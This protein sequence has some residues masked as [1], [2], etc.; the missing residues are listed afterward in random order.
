MFG[1][2]GL[3]ITCDGWDLQGLYSAVSPG[4]IPPR[5][6][7]VLRR[8]FRGELET[9][10]NGR[11]GQR[12]GM[13]SRSWLRFVL[14][15]ALYIATGPARVNS[16]QVRTAHLGLILRTRRVSLS[17]SFSPVVALQAAV[18]YPVSRCALHD[19]KRREFLKFVAAAEI[20]RISVRW[21]GISRVLRHWLPALW[22]SA[23]L[24]T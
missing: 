21:A 19:P 22:V 1:M 10:A 18:E 12:A 2:G 6:F 9:K 20:L 24:R 17:A 23:A 8:A 11:R 5:E 13:L 7:H 4:P 15:T 16:P 3:H 14:I